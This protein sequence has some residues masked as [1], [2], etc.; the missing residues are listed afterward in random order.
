MF[1]VPRFCS[2]SASL[3]VA[4][5]SVLLVI[6]APAQAHPGRSEGNSWLVN[7]RWSS[8]GPNVACVQHA[9]NVVHDV[10]PQY[11]PLDLQVDGRFGRLTDHDVRAFQWW[12]GLR[13]D[14][15][16]GPKTREALASAL[17]KPAFQNRTTARLR[18]TDCVR[19]GGAF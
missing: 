2:R 11:V 16:V 14:G 9:L 6:A 3:A 15:I 4:A 19:T 18:R 12:F 10:V 8:Q 13:A 17:S 7:L 5:A 1:R